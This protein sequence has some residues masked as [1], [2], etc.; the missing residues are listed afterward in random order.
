MTPARRRRGPLR[1]GVSLAPDMAAPL[2]RTAQDADR[3]GLDLLGVRDQPY[4]RDTADAPALMAAV[5]AVTS[6]IRVLPAV[7]CLPLRPPAVLAK[8]IATM[9]RLSGGRVELGL[10]AGTAWDGVEAYGGGRLGAAAA[11]RALEEAVQV[12][13]LHWSDQNGLRL[14]GDHYRFTTVQGGPAPAHQIGIWLGVTGPRGID[15]AGR[16]ADGWLAPSSLVPPKRLADGQLRLDAAAAAAGRDPAD[17]RRGYVL[18][19]AIDGQGSRGFLHGPSRQWI[20]ELTELAVGHGVDTFL[21][22]GAPE[23]LA[24]FAL[25]IVPAVRE[26]VTKERSGA[27]SAQGAAPGT[28]G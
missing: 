8:A 26:Q 19:G 16:V 9:D 11:R 5:L 28:P 10:G 3:F 4:R 21:Y 24:E 6:R 18:E 27:V 23:Q 12:I 1:F 25:E 22:A 17:I 7:A 2:I 20:Y 15:L 13:R 14:H